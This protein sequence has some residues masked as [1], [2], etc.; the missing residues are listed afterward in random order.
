MN[1][2]SL[3]LAFGFLLIALSGATYADIGEFV[4]KW[5]N[6]DPDT[7]GLTALEISLVGDQ[8]KVR[9]WGKCHP[10]DCDWNSVDAT[11]FGPHVRAALPRDARTLM[12]VFKANFKES[13]LIIDPSEWNKLRVEIM[14][15]FTDQSGRSAYSE[16]YTVSRQ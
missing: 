3:R 13:I 15:R 10:T 2:L 14:T 1:Q 12:A 8:L 16:I 7:G 4:G 6:V 11:A 5:R 9:A